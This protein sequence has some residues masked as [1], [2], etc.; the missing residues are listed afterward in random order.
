MLLTYH[1]SKAV[2]P[3]AVDRDSTT[4][5]GIE[6]VCQGQGW[7]P[8]P[9]DIGPLRFGRY[10]D[11][12]DGGLNW[13][14]VGRDP[15][16]LRVRREH[17]GAVFF[18]G[19]E[20]QVLALQNGLSLQRWGRVPVELGVHQPE[21]LSGPCALLLPGVAGA[22]S[23]EPEA[24]SVRTDRR[25][26]LQVVVRREQPGA[27]PHDP[28]GPSHLELDALQL[29]ERELC[30]LTLRCAPM[31]DPTRQPL[32]RTL[33]VSA[34]DVAAGLG[35]SRQRAAALLEE[36]RAHC[37]AN[38]FV[39]PQLAA[40]DPYLLDWLVSTGQLGADVLA[41]HARTASTACAHAARQSVGAS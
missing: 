11:H 4:A 31:L 33:V 29:T 41:Q 23:L 40:Q 2:T 19:V 25:Q 24:G 13:L 1:T 30:A 39:G 38:G 26:R 14:C 22:L 8:D 34:D 32:D 36:V 5:L 9:R 6:Q 37:I 27:V 12:P 21:P 28:D 18:T 16:E 10:Q 35:T 15:Q 7:P 3:M 20:W 17:C